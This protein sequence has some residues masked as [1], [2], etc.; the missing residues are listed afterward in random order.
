MNHKISPQKSGAVTSW[1]GKRH[2]LLSPFLF[3]LGFAL[4]V[5]NAAGRLAGRLAGSL[6]FA[7]AAGLGALIK[8]AGLDRM[9]SVHGNILLSNVCRSYHNILG[10][11]FQ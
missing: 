4:L 11:S 9:Y 1:R 10:R 7:A 3:I 5:R 2:C 6:A 8:I